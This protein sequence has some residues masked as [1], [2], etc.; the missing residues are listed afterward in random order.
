MNTEASIIIVD[1]EESI[2]FSLKKI[3]ERLGYDVETVSTLSSGMIHDFNNLLMIITG[4]IELLRT[5]KDQSDPELPELNEAYNATLQGRKI[6]KQIL[7]IGHCHHNG[8]I[9]ET[10]VNITINNLQNM[11]R[12]T[13]L[14]EV[15]L[16]L[17]LENDLSPAKINP[18]HMEQVLLNLCINARDAI[19]E[20]KNNLRQNP[21]NA[22]QARYDPLIKITTRNLS[23]KQAFLRYPS[24]KQSRYILTTISDTGCGI[25]RKIRP[26]IFEPFFTTKE[27][28]NGNGLGLFMVY[29]LIKKYNGEIIVSGKKGKGSSFEILLPA[30]KERQFTKT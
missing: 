13:L 2:R 28:E 11:L 20:K 5:E 24:L 12:K 22:V 30:A 7:N 1:D 18:G 14:K 23:A 15:K 3:L 25:P 16:D 27:A 17:C 9:K 19:R 8:H 21:D 6:I 10:D 4:N 29:K 26:R